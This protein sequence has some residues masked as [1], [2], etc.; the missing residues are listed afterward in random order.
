MI[1]P[2]K[3]GNTQFWDEFIEI[4]SYFRSRPDRTGA[5]DEMI[6]CN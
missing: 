4:E 6:V 3:S 2:K 5:D 1:V